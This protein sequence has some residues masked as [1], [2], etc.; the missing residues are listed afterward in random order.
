MAEYEFIKLESQGGVATLTLNRPEKR[1]A[2]S[3]ALRSE[4]IDALERVAQDRAI[5]AL[6]LTGAGAGFCA[7]GDV[8]GMRDRMQAPA[9]EVAFN[10]WSRQQRVH[11]AVD[12]LFRMPKPTIAAVNGAA[13]GLGADTALSCDFVMASEAASFTWSYIAR[14][15]IPDGGG[16]YFLPRRVGLPRAKELIYS[17]RKVAADEALRLGIADRLAPA[18]ELLARARAWAAE[19]AGGSPTALALSKSI[20]DQSFEL[21]AAQVFAMGS[22]AQGICYTSGEHRAAVGAFLEKTA[23]ARRGR[24]GGGS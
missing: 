23:Q 1:N 6:V 8:A 13:A 4:L 12:L 5:R 20:L 3:D 17:G 21:S 15:L 10:G 22:Q 18:D 2:I 16:M 11:H 9:G 19:L 14:G 7:G 24:K